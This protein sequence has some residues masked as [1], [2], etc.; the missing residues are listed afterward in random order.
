MVAK[1]TDSRPQSDLYPAVDKAKEARSEQAKR[2]KGAAAVRK[3]YAF[4][5]ARLKAENK[6]S[7]ALIDSL[8]L[9]INNRDAQL[10]QN[11]AFFPLQFGESYYDRDSLFI[12]S[13]RY[14]LDDRFDLLSQM[15]GRDALLPQPPA[16]YRR[17]DSYTDVWMIFAQVNSELNHFSSAIAD[18]NNEAVAYHHHPG[19]QSLRCL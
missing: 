13:Y 15:L 11:K 18:Y 6:R 17:P 10:N 4:E 1:T 8:R 7:R 14:L 9:E 3:K 19:P 12:H 2:E 5:A 16:G